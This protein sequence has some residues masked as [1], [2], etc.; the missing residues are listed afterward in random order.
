MSS[1]GVTV[2][3]GSAR[4][5]GDIA[6]LCG[7]SAHF[8][9]M[10]SLD[11]EI[12]TKFKIEVEDCYGVVNIT[13]ALL[14]IN[15]DNTERSALYLLLNSVIARFQNRKSGVQSSKAIFRIPFQFTQEDST[16]KKLQ[17]GH[18]SNRTFY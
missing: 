3:D 9:T 18:L 12:I 2:F 6:P 13:K 4:L 11:A 15:T 14:S 1:W 10:L 16:A 7:G 8:L 5:F 17:S